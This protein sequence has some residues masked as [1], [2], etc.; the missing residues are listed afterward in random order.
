VL[1]WSRVLLWVV[2]VP[3][4]VVLTVL[5]LLSLGSVLALLWLGR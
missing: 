2:L 1:W 3:L 5:V 4:A